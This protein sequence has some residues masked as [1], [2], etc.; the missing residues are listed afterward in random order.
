MKIRLYKNLAS[1]LIC[2]LCL[3]SCMKYLRNS[4]P[5][6][7][8]TPSP[9]V[10]AIEAMPSNE[11]VTISRKIE[12][13][14]YLSSKDKEIEE[15]IAVFIRE[16]VEK[17]DAIFFREEREELDI[18]P[19]PE[20]Q[21]TFNL[22]EKIVYNVRLG[23]KIS[24][25]GVKDN[26]VIFTTEKGTLDNKDCYI[27]KA[28]AEGGGMGYKLQLV[29]ES[30]I[31]ST[32]F[33][34]LLSTNTQSGSEDRKKRM[35]FFDDRIEYQKMKHCKLH[36]TCE[37]AEHYIDGRDEEYH[38]KRCKDRNHYV[39]RVRASHKNEKPTYDLLSAVLIARNFD[40]KIGGKGND[41]RL[42]DGRDLWEMSIRVIG[43]E[44]INTKIGDFDTL[45]LK[46]TARPLN[47]HAKRGDSFEGLFGL[48]GDIG[49][50][51]DKKS[52]IPIRVRGSYPLVFDIPIEIMIESIEVSSYKETHPLDSFLY[53]TPH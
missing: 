40:L 47:D 53:S 44:I 24:P 34:T 13:E 41:I 7:K 16:E 9:R 33:L 26:S 1:S 12:A 5:E 31:D 23:S 32:T 42:V 52:K 50:W 10:E 18:E 48:R 2:I 25:F 21:I 27:F 43:E 11:R 19:N 45:S 38:C 17:E 3:A 28:I 36:D 20:K 29:A 46:L 30:F 4:L 35:V 22:G 51:V 39:W 8:E 15:E 49:V 14:D 6:R 37:N